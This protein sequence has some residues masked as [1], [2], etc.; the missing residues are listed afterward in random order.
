MESIPAPERL[1]E[2]RP[3]TQPP[4][5]AREDSRAVERLVF[6]VSLCLIFIMAARA[7]VDS[8]L[9][10]HLTAGRETIQLG[11]PILVDRMSFTRAGAAWE[12]HSWLGEV[13]LY[14]VYQGGGSLLLCGLVAL[15]AA[16]SMGFVYAT[17]TG[18]GMLR[19]FLTLF[20]AVTAAL[21]WTP[22]PELFS[23][24]LFGVVLYILYL[25]KWKKRDRL[26]MLI[27][28]FILWSNLHGG[29]VLGL[30]LIGAYI[31][32][33][34]LSRLLLDS[35]ADRLEDKA[36]VRLGLWGFLSGLAVLIN[37]NGLNT[38]LEPFRT[39][40]VAALQKY[41]SEWASPNF[42]DIGQQAMLL[43]FFL[44]LVSFAL[45]RLKPSAADLVAF[46]LFGYIAFVARRNFGPF[47]MVAAPAISR[48]LLPAAQEW[49]EKFARRFPDGWHAITNFQKFQARQLPIGLRKTINLGL[50][51]A[52][53]LA[54]ILKVYAEANPSAMDFYTAQAFPV[55]AVNW[56][57]SHR[58][59]GNLLN[60][61]N[62]GGYLS[63]NLP[64]YPVFIDGRT[65]LYND[66]I[67]NQ[68]LTAVDAEPGWREMLDK[69]KIRL[70]LLEPAWPLAKIL[71]DEGWKEYYSDPQAVIFGR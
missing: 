71:P 4:G 40:Q 25:F 45:S 64:G 6:L 57:A 16:G 69:W 67:I 52:L 2:T 23:L 7:P 19:A 27:P 18:P 36:L 51:G 29:Y 20:A 5:R 43:L 14:L 26:W 61:Y 21:V 70:V 28:I 54:G 30:L 38:W 12:N 55:E 3:E 10:W 49:Q 17:M 59:A 13:I 42:H 33:E 63:W 39:V 37:P 24:V 62:W 50:I 41:I 48:S 35:P 66:E 65:D 56:I 15:L 22:R 9:W 11:H 60:S 44:G 32:G 68:W 1:A 46:L 58:P 47:A 31:A 8:D 34:L 53:A